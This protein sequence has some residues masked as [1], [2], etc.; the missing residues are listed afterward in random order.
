[1]EEQFQRMSAKARRQAFM[2]SRAACTM[3][4]MSSRLLRHSCTC[5]DTRPSSCLQCC[6]W[7]SARAAGVL[8][9]AL[10]VARK[11]HQ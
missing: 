7:F 1:M 2:T 9:R 4:C 5:A 11:Q 8:D 3:V 10:H 6:V